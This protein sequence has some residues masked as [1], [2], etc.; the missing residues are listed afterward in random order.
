MQ[1]A[2]ATF[3]LILA[4]ADLLSCMQEDQEQTI[5]TS[6]VA[7]MPT[8]TAVEAASTSEAEAGAHMDSRQVHFEQQSSSVELSTS[9]STTCPADSQAEQ[10]LV[11]VMHAHMPAIQA[12]EQP[13]N[14]Q[15]LF[16]SRGALAPGDSQREEAVQTAGPGPAQPQVAVQAGPS[17]LRLPPAAGSARGAAAQSFQAERATAAEQDSSSQTPGQAAMPAPQPGSVQVGGACECKC[18]I[19]LTHL[20]PV[21]NLSLDA[22]ILQFQFKLQ[23]FLL[24]SHRMMSA[25]CAFPAQLLS[26]A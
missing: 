25:Q 1:F 7:H 14:A 21:F 11:D 23:P 20:E 5:C 17:L 18:P 13:S 16:P 10:A 2:L 9:A 19:A 4:V 24:D 26:S 12:T 15:A 22:C 8:D 3:T 6:P